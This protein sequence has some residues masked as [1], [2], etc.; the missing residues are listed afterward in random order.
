MSRKILY[1]LVV[2]AML[3]MAF[4]VKGVG[5]QTAAAISYWSDTRAAAIDAPL[6][7][8]STINLNAAGGADPGNLGG[9]AVAPS[10]GAYQTH[11]LDS[12]IYT[13]VTYLRVRIVAPNVA[14]HVQNS[15]AVRVSQNDIGLTELGCALNNASGVIDFIVAVPANTGVVI[16]LASNGVFVPSATAFLAWAT[17]GTYPSGGLI[18]DMTA[19]CGTL[20]NRTV[21]ATNQADAGNGIYYTGM[22]FNFGGMASWLDVPTGTYNLGITDTT[23]NTAPIINSFAAYYP[24]IAV[25]PDLIPL[26]PCADA[27]V[28][29][30]VQV[31]DWYGAG[32][33]VETVAL[34]PNSF[35]LNHDLELGR[36]GVATD[37]VGQRKFYVNPGYLWDIAVIDDSNL[38]GFGY[39]VFMIERAFNPTLGPLLFNLETTLPAYVGLCANA[40]YTSALVNIDPPG[41]LEMRIFD[42]QDGLTSCK[43]GYDGGEFILTPNQDYDVSHSVILEIGNRC[44]KSLDGNQEVC[45]KSLNGP[46]LFFGGWL[47]EYIPTI[48]IWNFPGSDEWDYFQ[49]FGDV[50]FLTTPDVPTSQPG[51]NLPLT[52][53][54]VALMRGPW[55]DQAGNT[56]KLILAPDNAALD[57]FGNPIHDADLLPDVIQPCYTI[58]TPSTDPVL[59]AHDWLTTNLGPITDIGRYQYT[60]SL[61]HGLLPMAP[62]GVDSYSS[63]FSISSSDTTM[64]GTWSWSWIEAM[65][66]MGLT[67]GLTP[68][69]YGPDLPVTRAE[70]AQFLARVMDM[71]GLPAGTA[72]AFTDVASSYWA[73]DAIAMLRFYNI[74]DGC[75]SNTFCPEAYV[76][77]AE[78]AKFIESTFRT[79]HAYGGPVYWDTSF[80]VLVPGLTFIDVPSTYWANTWIEELFWDNLTSGCMRD[81]LTLYYCPDAN[82]TRGEMAKFIITAI[83]PAP[84]TQGFWPIL[85]PSK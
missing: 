67:S 52:S 48:P 69:T 82:V 53:G 60:R 49:Y 84:V 51:Y 71:Y 45:G 58:E 8:Y 68:T 72:P 30:T 20:D 37:V 12:D 81:G 7:Y 28:P 76:T 26:T 73:H 85:S 18:I 35:G 24:D 17:R 57:C 6:P 74:T 41:Q 80:H 54:D 55:T 25:L 75:G 64:G 43:P 31:T 50:P 70:M 83:Q 56:V 32:R 62:A 63:L 36:T 38:F 46:V 39:N 21:E 65:Y 15:W 79:I 9:C 27:V 47:Y 59:L 42:F 19:D 1:G 3:V 11:L 34:T 2:V 22:N 77:R 16:T 78:M 61:Q 66:E 40:G 10:F 33:D 23:A 4:G 5:V 13:T 29:L 14:D 44:D